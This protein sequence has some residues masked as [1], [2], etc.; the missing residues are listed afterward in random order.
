MPDVP[1]AN[2][3]VPGYELTVGYSAFGPAG[4]PPEITTRLNSEI[5]RILFLPEVRE[6]MATLGVVVIESTPDG[7]AKLLRRDAERYR[8]LIKEL[9]LTVE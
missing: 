7:T 8:Q 5:N 2:E 6:K 3:T 9:K 1:A 4:L